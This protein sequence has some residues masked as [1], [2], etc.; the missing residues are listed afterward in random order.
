MTGTMDK[1]FEPPETRAG[2]SRRRR[3]RIGLVTAVLVLAAG[4]AWAT[5]EAVQTCGSL[6]SGVHRVEGECIGVTDGSYVFDPAFAEVQKKI[7][8]ENVWVRSQPS[9]VT[10][11]LLNPLTATATS[12]LSK[13]EIRKQLEGAYTAQYRINHTTAVGDLRPSIQ[14]VLANEGSTANQW[15]PVVE[16]LVE[17][18]HQDNPLV[19]VV[20]M[21]ISIRQTEEAAKKLSEHGIPMV[22]A[23]ITADGLEHSNIDGLIRVSPS[24]RDYADILRSHLNSHTDFRSAILVFDSNSD[25]NGDL[26]TK[27]LRDALK[28]K[29]GDLIKF[30]DQAFTGGGL[31]ANVGA[32]HFS[33]ITPNICAAESKGL[34]VVLYAGRRGDFGGFLEALHDRVCSSTPM[35]VVA[36][37]IDPAV[38]LSEQEEELR[39]A[40]LTVVFLART[41]AR[42]WDQNTPGTPEHYRAFREEFKKRDFNLEDLTDDRVITM[43]DAFLTAAKAVRLATPGALRPGAPIATDVLGQ[44]MNLHDLNTVPGAG[45]TLSFSYRESG[46]GNPQGKP[47][48]VFQFP[49]S[50]PGAFQQVGPPYFTP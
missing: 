50:T 11:A 30:R 26:F 43:H 41:D 33:K 19:A 31:D 48:L 39:D 10:V 42:G 36:T 16:Q 18:T 34:D 13:D 4:T 3:K 27:T 6:R 45:G 14:L 35:T 8:D 23:I 24:N 15:R 49:S 46:A 22:G 37:G 29:M 47:M 40:K 28:E 2:R 17:M 20:G 1:T 38:V 12:A 32:G 21:G 44:L 25:S 5:V 7:A 9:Y